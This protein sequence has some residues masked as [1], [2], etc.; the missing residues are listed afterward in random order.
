MKPTKENFEK[1]NEE[2]ATKHDLDKF[3]NHP[4]FAFRYIEQKRIEKLIEAAEIKESDKI[5]EVGCGAGHILE[6]VRKG[7]LY[8]IDISEI[9]IERTKKRMGDKVELKKAPGENI[10]YEDKFF[11]KILCSEVIEHVI[12]PREVLK[13]ISRVLKDDGILSLS[14]PNEDVI[15]STKKFLKKTGLIKVIDNEKNTDGWELAAKDNLDEWHLHSFSLEL[16]E[17]FSKDIFKMTKVIKIPNA[18]FPARFVIQYR[19]I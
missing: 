8:G 4:N 3:Y 14:I 12:D 5:L 11:D 9:Q 10:P 6:K 17:K 18:V 1:W 15:N 2:L 7:K 16:A 19:K 13:E